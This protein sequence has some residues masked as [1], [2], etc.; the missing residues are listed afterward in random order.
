MFSSISRKGILSTSESNDSPVAFCHAD[1]KHDSVRISGSIRKVFQEVLSLPFFDV[2]SGK[3]RGRYDAD[4][5]LMR[6][7]GISAIFL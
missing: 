6:Q 3:V 4:D 1:R 5:R 2:I 7:T